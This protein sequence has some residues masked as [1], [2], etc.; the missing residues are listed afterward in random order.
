[1]QAQLTKRLLRPSRSKDPQIQVNSLNHLHGFNSFLCLKRVSE[2]LGEP[3]PQ[4]KL[5]LQSKLL[6]QPKLLLHLKLLRPVV[7]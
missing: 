1:M 2:N 4:T 5:L 6:L 7:L 3:H